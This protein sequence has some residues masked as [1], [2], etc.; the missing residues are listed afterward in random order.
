[1]RGIPCPVADGRSCALCAH[2]NLACDAL[3]VRRKDR[4]TEVVTTSLRAA[5]TPTA[6]P[7]TKVHG[8]TLR[9]S[10]SLAQLA[11]VLIAV[12]SIWWLSSSFGLESARWSGGKS[13]SEEGE[14]CYSIVLL[15]EAHLDPLTHLVLDLNRMQTDPHQMAAYKD[16]E[17]VVGAGR[18]LVGLYKAHAAGQII[19]DVGAFSTPDAGA[20]DPFVE[21]QK[22]VKQ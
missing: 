5:K 21:L 22:V 11:V 17:A 10:F 15:N 9:M 2:K 14:R 8:V 1:M 6:A 18:A 3:A 7:K 16:R 19:T 20:E 4:S 12:M 13:S